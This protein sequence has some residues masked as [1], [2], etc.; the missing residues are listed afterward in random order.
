MSDFKLTYVTNLEGRDVTR[1]LSGMPMNLPED[2]RVEMTD[3]DK[4]IGFWG[5]V[6]KA[7]AKKYGK[8]DKG[9]KDDHYQRG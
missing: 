4:W 1:E 7:M 2:E 5:R 6:D 9:A 3:W 8:E